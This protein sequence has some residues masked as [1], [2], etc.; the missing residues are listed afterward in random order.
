[1]LGEAGF[2]PNT[3]PSSSDLALPLSGKVTFQEKTVDLA[4]DVVV[5]TDGQLSLGGCQMAAP[6]QS[7]LLT[8]AILY[9][10]ENRVN[11][12]VLEP[13]FATR[14]RSVMRSASAQL[15]ARL[16]DIVLR[17]HVRSLT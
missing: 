9:D 3:P 11:A 16:L 4:A 2:S 7:V 1:M 5:K 15:K 10:G 14:Y 12:G 8:L 17:S 6:T 13:K